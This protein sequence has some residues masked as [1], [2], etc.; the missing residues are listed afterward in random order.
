MLLLSLLS[1]PLPNLIV[2]KLLKLLPSMDVQSLKILELTKHKTTNSQTPY[3]NISIL[4][5][6]IIMQTNQ[7]NRFILNLTFKSVLPLNKN[8]ELKIMENHLIHIQNK[9]NP[10]LQLLLHLMLNGD[11][12]GTL[13]QMIKLKKDIP[14]KFH[15]ISL[16]S[17]KL[18]T[19]GEDI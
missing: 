15:K 7:L 19:L 17:N 3:K 16:N 4:D 13:A 10:L 9:T 5:Q 8:K 14:I 11:I 18:W 2:N 6:K 1:L 12:S